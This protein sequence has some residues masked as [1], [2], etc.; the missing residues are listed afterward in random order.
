MVSP[1]QTD[2]RQRLHDVLDT[3]GVTL[4]QIHEATKR[5]GPDCELG[6]T[7]LS[8]MKNSKWGEGIFGKAKILSDALDL[9]EAELAA[10]KIDAQDGRA[11]NAA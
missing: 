4:T 6:L 7:Q 1:M 10:P 5:L 3:K 8:Y 2:I 11:T 9:I